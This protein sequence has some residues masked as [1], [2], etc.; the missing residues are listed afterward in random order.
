ME[1][2]KF[3]KFYLKKPVTELIQEIRAHLI[4]G[5]RLDKEWFE[6]LKI[7]IIERELSTEERQT[8]NH[9]LSD[10]FDP[11]NEL[12]S[13]NKQEI[14]FEKR[15]KRQNHSNL[16]I[17]P[18]NIILAGKNMKRV[19]YFVLI[20]L[21]SVVGAILTARSSTNSDTIKNAYAFLSFVTLISNIII[22][23]LLHSAGDNL[24]NSFYQ[25]EE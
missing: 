12:E 4:T 22:L 25:K 7:H 24:E 16:I 17:N 18:T 2:N 1:N 19:V 10:E 9:I 23:F 6:A 13:F 3:N 8:I 15:Q 11:I 20:M 14:E 21:L 5:N